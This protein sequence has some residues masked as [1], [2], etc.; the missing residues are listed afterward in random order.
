MHEHIIDALTLGGQHTRSIA[1][2]RDMY[3]DQVTNGYLMTPNS[4]AALRQIGEGLVAGRAQRAWK[5]VGPYGSGKSALGVI[6]AQLMAGPRRHPAAAKCLAAIAPEIAADF[7]L[8]NRLSLAVVGSRTSFG[9]ALAASIELALQNIKETKAVA[10]FRK[11][12]NIRKGTYKDLP[13]NSVVGDLA[14]DFAT[15]IVSEGYQGLALLIDEVGKFVEY[16][17]LYPEQGDL[18]ALQQVAEYACKANDNKLVVVAMLHQHLA[19]YAAGVGRTLNDEWHKVAAR[20]EEIPFDE[21]VERYAHFAVHALGVKPAL[22]KHK[23]LVSESKVVYARALKLGILRSTSALDKD[24]FEHSESL[25]PLHPLTL[26]AVA[27]VSKRYGQSERSFH[28]FIKGR[29]PKGLR[30]F[31]AGHAIGAWYRLTDLYDFLSDGNSLRFRDLGAER[32]WTFAMAAVERLTQDAIALSALKTIAVLELVQAGINV[33]ATAEVISYALGEDDVMES[34]SALERLVD[35]GILLKR[36]KQSEYSLAVSDAVNIEALYERAANSNE[37][38]LVVRGAAK[39]LSKRL[40]VA[41]RHY[42]ATG[43]IR[44][45]GIL[46]GTAEAW[47]QAQIGKSD[48]VRPDAWLKLVLVNKGSKAE[49]QF[50]QRLEKEQDPLSISAG[51]ALSNEG[52]AALAEFAIWQ[53]VLGDVNSKRLDP[54][55]TRYVE[56]RLQEAGDAVERLVTSALVPSADRPGPIYWHVG[57]TIPHSEFMNVSQLASWL[58]DKVY[59]KTP[60][61]V[62]EL[63]NKD[64]PASAIVLARQRM[65]DVYLSGDEARQISGD[66]EYPPERLIHT[67]LLCNTGIWREI[68]GRWGLHAPI[69]SEASDISAIWTAISLQLDAEEPKSFEQVLEALATPPLGV[70]AGPA[71]IWIAVYLLINRA[72]CAVFERGTLILEL[73][74]EHLQRMY[75]N[76]QAFTM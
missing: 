7:H 1:I 30:D 52:R 35:Q 17:A 19:S 22:H 58:F 32:R 59:Y 38:D 44:T 23:D 65:F 26:A 69:P 9:L 21:P 55:T 67:T 11:K 64:K 61:I 28:A 20:F 5:I 27:T 54:W 42:D 76:P 73:T 37:N 45:M 63:I 74:S 39:A 18:I 60:R 2:N 13:I 68:D 46:V 72:R 34:S 53:S 66:T 40:V 8:A 14:G 12:L 51:L 29:E 43:T 75:K 31:A 71:G 47:P 56:D 15:V 3:D 10:V 57:S 62:N 6:L 24:L 25:Y 16:A 50:I 48:E 33:P 36:R 70:R 49:Q 4:L 41:N